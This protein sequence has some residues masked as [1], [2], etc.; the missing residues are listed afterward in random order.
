MSIRAETGPTAQSE[1]MT[2]RS[3]LPDLR[4]PHGIPNVNARNAPGTI[5]SVNS[6][7][8]NLTAVLGI[9]FFGASITWST[10]FSG[11]HGNLVLISW[12]ACLFI[13]GAVAAAAASMLV[14]SDE[15]IVAAY[16]PRACF[17]SPSLY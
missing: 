4:N 3:A 14:I 17:S 7:M 6:H 8:K 13:V 2:L 11:T 5:S 15:D 12:T 9:A 1:L 16:P 10:I